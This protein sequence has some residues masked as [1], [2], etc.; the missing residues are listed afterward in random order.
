MSLRA[1]QQFFHSLAQLL[2]AGVTFPQA[3]EKL[4]HTAQG[5][6]REIVRRMHRELEKGRTVAEACAAADLGRME[7][8]VLSAVERAGSL[9]RGLE[10][11][12]A[13]FGAMASARGQ[14][15]A[16]LAYP[17]F[18]L[19]L[20][21][22]LLNLP[23][24][25][26]ANLQ[27]YLQA[28]LPLLAVLSIGTTFL[29]A[30]FRLLGSLAHSSAVI[31]GILNDIPAV[32]GL[33]RALAMSRFCL[34][35]ELQLDAGINVLDALQAAGAAS[36]SAKIRRAVRRALPKVRAG[37]QVGPLLAKSRAF[38]PEVV[39]GIIVGEESG[40]LG[41]E[42]RRLSTVQ[43]EKAFA[44]LSM[45][46]EWVPRLIYLGVVAYVGYRIVTV[47]KGTLDQ[48]MKLMDL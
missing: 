33:R 16:K 39:E 1:R 14:I 47:Y 4:G 7:A 13:Y 15:L 38:D 40:T 36:Q 10:Q 25:V 41:S 17:I 21:I 12:S 5:D 18:I 3:L 24:L 30:F 42:L 26:S 20:G 31:E 46:A 29:Y 19:V 37:E 34:A 23:L 22:L 11:L 9:D 43:S 8:A 45:L 27:R 2:R 48:M 6:T 35:Y 28:T 32:G 44:R